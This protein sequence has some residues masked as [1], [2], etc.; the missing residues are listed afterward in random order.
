MLKR[1]KPGVVRFHAQK[2]CRGGMEFKSGFAPDELFES[3]Q[4]PSA[5]VTQADSGIQSPTP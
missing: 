3:W 2:P 1:W 5:T 4:S